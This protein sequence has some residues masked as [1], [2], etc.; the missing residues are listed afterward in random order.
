MRIL[1]ISFGILS[2]FSLLALLCWGGI[3]YEFNYFK[4]CKD[5]NSGNIRLIKS[6][7]AILPDSITSL[8]FKTYNVSFIS[9]EEN[10]PDINLKGVY[11]YNLKMHSYLKTKLG[12]NYDSL[13]LIIKKQSFVYKANEIEKSWHP[14]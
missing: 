7:K 13:L 3:F 8:I 9:I 12:G 4:A 14:R 10:D 1:K 11:F 5:I 2:L 6:Q